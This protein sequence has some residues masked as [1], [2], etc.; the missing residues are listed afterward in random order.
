MWIIICSCIWSKCLYKNLMHPI[1][2]FILRAW[3]VKEK[4]HLVQETLTNVISGLSFKEY[5]CFTM[6]STCLR[7]F[8]THLAQVLPRHLNE[9]RH[10]EVHQ[11]VSP[12]QLQNH[13]RSQKIIGAEETRGET[14]A[15]PLLNKP[16]QEILSPSAVLRLGRELH[17]VLTDR[18]RAF[19]LILIREYIKK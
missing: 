18:Q 10:G 17:R 12:G 1:E 15:L 6:F 5:E 13:V 14:L 3:K 2:T 9:V 11:A 7:C 16:A 8:D 4:G 19:S